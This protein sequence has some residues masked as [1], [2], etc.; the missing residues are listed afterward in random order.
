MNKTLTNCNKSE[1]EHASRKPNIWGE[2]LKK[3]IG[4]NLEQDVRNEEDDKSD[5]VSIAVQ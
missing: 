2:L 4:R 5:V 1:H 3:N